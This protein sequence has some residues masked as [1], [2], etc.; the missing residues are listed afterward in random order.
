MRE[1]A[2][3][4]P[5]G[6]LCL[7]VLSA[8]PC[9]A[10][11]D[12]LQATRA[13]ETWVLS[14]SGPSARI[15]TPAGQSLSFGLPAASEIS[16]FV[17][18]D[19]GWALAGSVQD[20][21]DGGRRRLFLMTGGDTGAPRALAEPAGQSGP[22]R[23]FPVL[24]AD[25]GKLAGLAWLEGNDVGSFTVRAAAWTG[26]RFRAPEA[27]SQ[28]GPGSQMGL[29]GAVL[30]DGSWLLAWSAFDGVDNEI[31]WSRRLGGQL[32]GHWLPARPVS[33]D[34]AVPDITPAVVATRGGALL[35][36]SRYEEEGYRLRLVR[37][38][39]GEWREERAG[40]P[41]GSL[42][43]SWTAGADRPQLLYFTALPR[44]WVAA[45][46]D[47]SGKTV[48]EA[49]VVAPYAERPAIVGSGEN[50]EMRWPARRKEAAA[51]WR[52]TQ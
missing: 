11:T 51:A 24:L 33:T 15:E 20:P 3:R 48:R 2:P 34:N 26:R 29:S 49:A 50:V 42:Y 10:Q 45:E 40:G 14:T 12:S 52:V 46:L 16:S 43:P 39:G 8:I 7:F 4:T 36:W 25:G 37:F 30:G 38:E 41:S 13:G 27:V 47:G 44:G 5:F 9:L 22:E 1:L 6:A 17:A 19:H 32:D 18:L 21:G 31:V 28:P 35:A 23:R